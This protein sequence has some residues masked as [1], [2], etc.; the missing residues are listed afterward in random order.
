AGKA[1]R[2]WR[3]AVGDAAAAFDDALQGRISQRLGAEVGD[4]VLLRADGY[5]AYQ[6]AVVADD[7]DQGITHVVR[8]ADLLDSTPR[9]IF[10][11]SCLG[12]ATPS[13]VHL[14]VAVNPAGE[15]LSKQ[16][17]APDIDGPDPVPA[18]LAALRFLGQTPPDG[19]GDVAAVWQWALA[20]WRLENVPHCRTLP[21]PVY[22][23]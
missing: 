6:L 9:Q 7:A 12:F 18:M 13:Y 23:R 22:S 19:L 17:C 20:N 1:A 21:A 5:F 3:L 2:A 4:F 8:G 14:P 15:K 10:L 16:T 11:Q